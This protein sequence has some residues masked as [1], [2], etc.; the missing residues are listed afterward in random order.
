ML[1]Y[2]GYSAV[3]S[4]PTLSELAEMFAPSITESKYDLG[5]AYIGSCPVN[6]SIPAM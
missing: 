5:I 2:P 1:I 4:F 3:M 6:K